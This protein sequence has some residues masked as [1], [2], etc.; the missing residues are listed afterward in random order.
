MKSV[1]IKCDG[2]V[3]LECIRRL[4]LKLKHC[5]KSFIKMVLSHK[6]VFVT[7]EVGEPVRFIQCNPVNVPLQD[8]LPDFLPL[9]YKRGFNR[10]EQI[11]VDQWL[12]QNIVSGL[13]TKVP[14]A[15]VLSPVLIV[16]KLDED[17]KQKTRFLLDARQINAKILSQ[18]SIPFPDIGEGLKNLSKMSHHTS[19]D[20]KSAFHRVPI[21]E[22]SK[23]YTAFVV[24]TGGMV[25]TYVFNSLV[26]GALSSPAIFCSIMQEILREL[27]GDV[28]TYCFVDDNLTSSPT[29]E[30]HEIDV[31]KVLTLFERHW[32]VIDVKK[33]EFNQTT[34]MWCGYKIGDGKYGPDPDRLNKLDDL[35]GSIPSCKFSQLKRWQMTFGLTNYYRKFV[36]SYSRIE[37][38]IRERI[39]LVKEGRL[40]Y[41]EAD[42][43]NYGDFKIIVAAIKDAALVITD[44]TQP[45]RIRTD[46]SITALG[47]VVETM[48]KQP[49]MF[50]GRKLS[51]A[52]KN[53]SMFELEL[54]GVLYAIERHKTSSS[55]RRKWWWSPTT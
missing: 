4:K 36:P 51:R 38:G 46:A 10:D 42:L 55:T 41:R 21:S 24:G 47:F 27:H 18:V 35:M 7:E 48:D 50:G 49:V 13:I 9:P 33:S 5:S 54:I 23:T 26:Q 39:D 43:I 3:A 16:R 17:G 1:E 37:A 12:K 20:V 8:N 11:A 15:K 52:E 25:G 45:L 32:V 29:E 30:Q 40:N 31:D 28:Q 19:M 53:L 6:T 44:R 22:K 34:V 2:P 14:H